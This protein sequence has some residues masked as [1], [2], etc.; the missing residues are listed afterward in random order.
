MLLWIQ[1]G[2]YDFILSLAPNNLWSAQYLPTPA[3]Y[4]LIEKFQMF[5]SLNFAISLILGLAKFK[6]ACSYT[7]VYENF[8][9]RTLQMKVCLKRKFAKYLI[10]QL[11]YFEPGCQI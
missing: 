7:A 4:L 3:T 8:S 11:D 5:P 2:L 9:L 10:H 1:A 6:S